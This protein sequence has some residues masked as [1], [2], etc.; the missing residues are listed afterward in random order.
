VRSRIERRCR[1]TSARVLGG[2]RRILERPAS[3]RALVGLTALVLLIGLASADRPWAGAGVQA[4]R[5]AVPSTRV[6]PIGVEA[7]I[8]QRSA[9]VPRSLALATRRLRAVR[10]ARRKLD[11]LPASRKNANVTAAAHQLAQQERRLNQVIKTLRRWTADAASR[12]REVARRG[13]IDG[14]LADVERA[15]TALRGL[16]P[17]ETTPYLRA[18]TRHLLERRTGLRRQRA[19]VTEA[20]AGLERRLTVPL[21]S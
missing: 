9:T 18:A 17:K 20:I 7:L 13:R 4:A 8:R 11:D 15:L 5:A 12:S 10:D 14:D 1:S 19:A 16:P 6:R 21:P 2:T 3:R